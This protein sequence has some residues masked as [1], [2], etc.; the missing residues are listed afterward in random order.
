[1]QFYIGGAKFTAGRMGL[2]L[3]LFPAL[4]AL[5]QKG[6]RAL[7]SDLFAF[8]TAA[9]II[10]A[11]L[12]TSGYGSL[13]SAVAES[14]EFFGGYLVARGLFFGP[15]SL[16]TFVRVLKV[17]TAATIILA[18]AD[19]MSGRW[20]TRD[21][22][23]AILH[24]SS[25]GVLIRM[26][27]VRATSTLDHPIALGAFCA[28]VTTIFLYSERSVLRQAFYVG[29]C[30]LG[31]YLARSSTAII[32]ILII[33]SVYVYDRTLRRFSWRWNVFW[34]IAAGLLVAL[35]MMTSH[36][37]ESLIYHL[38]LDPET[39]YY[40]IMIWDAATSK[41]L[42]SPLTGYAF[43]LLN[44]D[45]LDNSVDSVW[46]VY[47]LRFGLP[48]IAFLILTN[49]T[50][51]WPAGQSLRKPSGDFCLDEMRPALTIVLVMFSLIGLT[52]HFWN[53]MWIFWGLCIG[54]RASLRE[55]SIELARVRT[56]LN[57]S[58]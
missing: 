41:I 27:A 37:L 3:L 53:Y 16:N 42:Q 24:T 18:I 21:A 10:G 9:W 32:S 14:L 56:Q 28:L 34:M 55:R 51:L 36:P 1:V 44:D 54:M 22:F 39:G 47:S 33:L 57:Q 4:A 20:I 46:L 15:A 38:T 25:P 52:V 5:C 43:N 8:G 7:I 50:S 30:F 35:S 13:S 58:Q 11:T 49:I 31:C 2:V 48:M 19:S 23:A 40:R 26:G 12:T 45:I 29:L 17:F 6:R